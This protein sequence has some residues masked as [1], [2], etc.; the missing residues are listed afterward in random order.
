MD[1]GG[2]LMAVGV[3]KIQLGARQYQRRRRGGHGSKFALPKSGIGLKGEKIQ[4]NPEAAALFL[5]NQMFILPQCLGGHGGR[6]RSRP[7][8]AMRHLVANRA[9]LRVGVTQ[10]VGVL[11]GD[12]EPEMSAGCHTYSIKTL[13]VTVV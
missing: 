12:Q 11:P 5:P 8:A 3:A 7:P 13:N 1:D 9:R 2:P 4:R 10:L 6:V